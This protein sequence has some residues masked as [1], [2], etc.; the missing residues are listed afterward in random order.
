MFYFH[1]FQFEQFYNKQH[2]GRNLTWLHHLSQAEVKMQT[3]TK[4]YIVSVTLKYK[5]LKCK[6]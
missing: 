2:N 5:D 4:A 6:I 1:F 3:Q